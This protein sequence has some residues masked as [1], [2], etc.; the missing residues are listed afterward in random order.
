[1]WFLL[2]L[3]WVFG[4]AGNL[5]A[6]PLVNDGVVT[7]SIDAPG[8]RDE[9]TFDVSAGEAAHI[10]VVKT[11]GTLGPQFWLYNPDGTLNRTVSASTVADRKSVV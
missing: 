3:V 6:T 10:R 5:A 1:M 4:A 2:L 7:G 11:S 9:F 8:E